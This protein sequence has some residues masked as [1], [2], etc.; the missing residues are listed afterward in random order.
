M[1][2]HLQN[3]EEMA[4]LNSQATSKKKSTSVTDP[5]PNHHPS[6]MDSSLGVSERNDEHKHDEHDEDEEESDMHHTL[7]SAVQVK[8]RMMKAVLATQTSLKAIR[9]SEPSPELFDSVQVQVYGSSSPLSSV[10]Q[11]VITSPTLVTLSCFDPQTAPQVRDAIRDNMPGMNFQPTLQDG[12]VLVPIP[13]VSAETRK[14]IVKQLGKLAE[15]TKQR[16]RRIRRAAM[17]VVKKAKDGKMEGVS[18]DDAYRCG[19]DIDVVTEECIQSLN[20]V[21]LKKQKDVMS[22]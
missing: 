21:V 2:K 12:A 19:K 13:R 22:V 9:G 3:L 16:I 15:D 1:G 7:P 18:E 5:L 4:H 11:V 20:D 8:E 17:E 14:A 6:F 10:A